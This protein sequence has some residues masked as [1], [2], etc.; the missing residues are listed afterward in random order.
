MAVI[1]RVSHRVG[2]MYLG[3]IVEYGLRGQI[4]ENPMS[5]LI[6]KNLCLQYR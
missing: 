5:T 3:E 2:V 4:F 6:Q 1:E